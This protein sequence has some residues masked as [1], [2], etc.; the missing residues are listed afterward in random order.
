MYTYVVV[1]APPERSMPDSE[2]W[3][4][5][6]PLTTCGDVQSDRTDR[7]DRIYGCSVTKM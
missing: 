3:L 6:L 5:D 1:P 7:T 2:C 4:M